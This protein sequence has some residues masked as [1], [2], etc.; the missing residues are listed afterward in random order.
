MNDKLNKINALVLSACNNNYA[1]NEDVR[2]LLVE[3]ADE[4]LIPQEEFSVDELY[5]NIESRD[6]V[7]FRVLKLAKILNSKKTSIIDKCGSYYADS[8]PCSEDCA[9]CPLSK[10][11]Y[12]NIM[13]DEVL[14]WESISDNI[15]QYA[16]KL[17]LDNIHH[18]KVSTTGAKS[19]PS[20]YK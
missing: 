16:R 6:D 20:K 12:E 19:D 4:K 5:A 11:H 13:Y 18:F 1:F 10:H 14:N 3:I 17:A 7:F 9:F 15:L 2:Q 8:R